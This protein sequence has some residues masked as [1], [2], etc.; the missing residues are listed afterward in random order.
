MGGAETRHRPDDGRRCCRVGSQCRGG[1]SR[2][3]ASA[4]S[5]YG[6][7]LGKASAA[8]RSKHGASEHSF[9]ARGSRPLLLL[10]C[11]SWG[12]SQSRH[13]RHDAPSSPPPSPPSPLRSW[14][15]QHPLPSALRTRA[16]TC[17][18]P[19][20]S[21]QPGPRA[22]SAPRARSVRAPGQSGRPR[23]AARL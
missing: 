21:V 9:R 16:L 5:R 2:G 20:A 3:K 22:G 12:A 8:S 1:A 15:C 4:A 11:P 6:A 17:R 14:S 10:G 19:D 18:W 7:P 13:P 23:A